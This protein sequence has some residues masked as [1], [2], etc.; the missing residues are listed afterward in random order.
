MKNHKTTGGGGIQLNL[1]ETGNARGRPILF[2]P[3]RAFAASA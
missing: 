1:V 2:I 3:L